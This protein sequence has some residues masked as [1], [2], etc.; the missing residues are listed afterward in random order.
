MK[1]ID[2]EELKIIYKRVKII[3]IVFLIVYVTFIFLTK[4]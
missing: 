2:K 4:L 3:I 1:E